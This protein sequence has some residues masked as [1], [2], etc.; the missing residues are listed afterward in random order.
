MVTK[1]LLFITG[2]TGEEALKE[3]KVGRVALA[4]ACP[5]LPFDMLLDVLTSPS[6]R[7]S[8]SQPSAPVC[9]GGVAHLLV[10]V[11]CAV[12]SISYMLT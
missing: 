11:A 5:L 10:V 6:R 7:R 8:S 4:P 9:G 1:L 3:T 2:C 12:E